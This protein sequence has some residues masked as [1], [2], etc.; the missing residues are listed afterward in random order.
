MPSSINI[1]NGDGNP[2]NTTLSTALD[3]VNDS[4]TNYPVGCTCTTVDLAT[5]ADVV[6]TA[7]PALLLGVYVI[8]GMSA[9]AAII[10]DSATAIITLPASTA[11]GTQIDCKGATFATNIT[12]ESDNSGTGTLLVFWRAL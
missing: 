2:V 11:A 5:D 9:H 12:V 4:I 7:S 3:R 8:V 1:A 10:K 6:V